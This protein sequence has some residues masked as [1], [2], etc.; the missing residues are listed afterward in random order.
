MPTTAFSCTHINN[1][2][3]YLIHNKI[4]AQNQLH[5]HFRNIKVEI[6]NIQNIIYYIVYVKKHCTNFM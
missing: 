5:K 4:S 6:F 1:Y 2:K 3:K